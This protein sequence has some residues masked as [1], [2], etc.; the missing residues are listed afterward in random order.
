MTGVP[1]V[2]FRVH[3]VSAFGI[4]PLLEK[5]AAIRALPRPGTIGQLM[6]FL[7]MVNF[8]RRFIKGAAGVLKPLTDALRGASGKAAPMLEAFEGSKKQMVQ[9]THFAH[10]GKKARLALYVDV[11]GTHVGAALQQEVSAGSLQPLGF[12]SRKLNTAEQKYSAFDR[13]LLAV[14][15]A[16]RHFKWAIKEDACTCSQTTSRSPSPCTG[17]LMS[18]QHVS[19]I[20]SPTWLSTHQTCSWKGECVG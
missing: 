7:G 19:S 12:F 2:Q 18:G 8:Y 13:E 6:S 17:S 9:A 4:I 5:V 15:A 3:I 16:I 1:E 20:T 10:L 11:S 14:Y